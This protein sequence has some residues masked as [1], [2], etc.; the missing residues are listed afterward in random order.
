MEGERQVNVMI[1]GDRQTVRRLSFFAETNT[2]E[3]MTLAHIPEALG[4]LRC[5][6]YDVVILS[7]LGE[8]TQTICRQIR[9][10]SQS[11]IV[12]IVDPTRADWQ[13]LD[14][15]TIDGFI[16]QHTGR[17]ELSARL[18]AIHRRTRSIAANNC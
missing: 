5:R 9:E 18:M 17:N 13:Y 1:L 3:L 14:S 15:L 16:L 7:N 8:A 6:N 10:T 2:V 4:A 11:S 12:M